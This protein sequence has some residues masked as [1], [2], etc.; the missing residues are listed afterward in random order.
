MNIERNAIDL[1]TYTDDVGNEV[2]RVHYTDGSGHVTTK[3]PDGHTWE[4]MSHLTGNV[5][6]AQPDTV[7]IYVARYVWADTVL[8]W[9]EWQHQAK[10]NGEWTH[11]DPP[12]QLVPVS[13]STNV[14]DWSGLPTTEPAWNQY[15]EVAGVFPGSPVS[16][17]RMN[18]ELRKRW[19]DASSWEGKDDDDIKVA[20]AEWAVSVCTYGL[21]DTDFRHQHPH[22]NADEDAE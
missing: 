9:R 20:A 18:A 6:P 10:S 22:P 19:P 4:S 17:A 7:I 11:S 8:M 21:S 16:A 3:H 1:K 14:D 2:T 15:P 13:V 12:M 5:I